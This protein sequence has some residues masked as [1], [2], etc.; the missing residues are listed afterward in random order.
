[1]SAAHSECGNGIMMWFVNAPQAVADSN[2][3]RSKETK[4]THTYSTHAPH[5]HTC[6]KQWLSS[7]EHMEMLRFARSVPLISGSFLMSLFKVS[8]FNSGCWRLMPSCFFFPVSFKWW[9][10]SSSIIYNMIW[11]V[12][13]F[14]RV[15]SPL[16]DQLT[17]LQLTSSGPKGAQKQPNKTVKKL[18]EAP[19]PLSLRGCQLFFF[20]CNDLIFVFPSFVPCFPLS[21]PSSQ[22]QPPLS[23]FSA[24]CGQSQKVRGY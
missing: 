11:W 1:M 17:L 15:Q 10:W 24:G 6:S 21:P 9:S 20:V 23:L 12:L 4:H 8:A 18:S 13:L 7:D 16:A 2:F 3:C 19:V 22:R 14:L 5:T